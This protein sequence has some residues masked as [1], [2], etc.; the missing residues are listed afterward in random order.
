[1]SLRQTIFTEFEKLKDA[2]DA[3][4]GYRMDLD[5]TSDFTDAMSKF[6][7][8]DALARVLANH[9]ATSDGFVN[10][11]AVADMTIVLNNHLTQRGTQS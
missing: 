11:K 1:M 9:L 4:F 6:M 8:D 7:D 2:P 3:D 5:E 10:E